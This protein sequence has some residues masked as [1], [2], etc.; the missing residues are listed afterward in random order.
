V[1]EQDWKQMNNNPNLW[2]TFLWCLFDFSSGQ[3]NEGSVPGI[4]TKG[5]ITQ[6]R[7]IKKDPYFF[8]KANWNSAPMVY[9][10]SRR[11]ILRHQA[12]TDIKVYANC[13]SVE[14]KVNGISCGVVH[15]DEIKVCQWKNILLQPGG[16]VIEAL[17]T[18]NGKLI[19]D[20]CQWV[21][22]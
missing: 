17:A 15:P 19:K 20:A 2:G 22:K 10:T 1:H 21:L 16:N 12:T 3:R 6:D 5:M 13:N 11:M 9:I 4:N 8:Y 14:L 7:L 18:V